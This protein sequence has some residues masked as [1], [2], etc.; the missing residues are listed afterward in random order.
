APPGGGPAPAPATPTAPGAPSA[1]AAGQAQPQIDPPVGETEAPETRP[2]EDTYLTYVYDSL[3]EV[4]PRKAAPAAPP[5]HELKKR[6]APPAK[7]RPKPP[8]P[9]VG[10]PELRKDLA[11]AEPP[12]AEHPKVETPARGRSAGK[13]L[14][15]VQRERLE[16]AFDAD[17]SHVRVHTDEH[18]R[19]SARLLGAEAYTAGDHVYFGHS[20]SPNA[21]HEPLLAH[22]L[23]HVLQERAP[24][25]APLATGHDQA[26]AEAHEAGEAVERGEKPKPVKRRRE[27]VVHRVGTP[28]A[29]AAP[30]PTT[31]PA[32][33]APTQGP[34]PHRQFNQAELRRILSTPGDERLEAAK[35]Q[36]MDKETLWKKARQEVWTPRDKKWIERPPVEMRF[37]SSAALPRRNAF[38]DVQVAVGDVWLRHGQDRETDSGG[39][40]AKMA[41]MIRFGEPLGFTRTEG[42]TRE[43]TLAVYRAFQERTNRAKRFPIPDTQPGQVWS[44]SEVTLGLNA[45]GFGAM[46]DEGWRWASDHWE[47][48]PQE[49]AQQQGPQEPDLDPVTRGGLAVF[50]AHHVVPMWLTSADHPEYSR[51]NLRNLAPWH[52]DFH[53]TNHSFHQR[54]T[55]LVKN[56]TDAD[57]YRDFKPGTLFKITELT[58]GTETS[59]AAQ[60]NVE[61][62]QDE[63]KFIPRPSGA[64]WWG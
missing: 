15:P 10:R 41:E 3:S 57:D 40:Q 30:A 32:G 19:E 6:L 20:R 13:P 1:P 31:P 52:R 37:P 25:D 64:L 53:Q 14:A 22:E 11:Q 18:A 36:L 42:R 61:V 60:P 2:L 17:L 62:S 49:P 34:G 23:T 7:P 43:D 39:E 38:G 46:W 26:E 55:Q 9:P 21:G 8:K 29:P 56:A 51:D 27:A 45:T 4:L 59:R 63:K 54:T 33:A 44:G 50:Q 35:K 58:G 5:E 28:S 16:Q 48:P 47:R 24:A 12:P